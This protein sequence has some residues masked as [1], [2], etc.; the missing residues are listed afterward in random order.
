MPADS[1]K[2]IK[3]LLTK[4]IQLV[5]FLSRFWETRCI[6]AL[7]LVHLKNNIITMLT[8][9]DFTGDVFE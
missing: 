5:I 3:N 1:S 4:V 2:N 7:S 6:T 8:A 9:F